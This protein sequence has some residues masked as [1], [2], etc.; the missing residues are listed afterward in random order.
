MVDIQTGAPYPWDPGISS[1]DGTVDALFSH[2]TTLHVGGT[3]KYLNGVPQRG[4]ASFT[5][6]VPVELVSFVVD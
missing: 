2:G 1:H 4:F 6:L 3:F 5:D